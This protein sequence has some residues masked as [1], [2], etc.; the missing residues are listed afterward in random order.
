MRLNQRNLPPLL[1]FTIENHA[2]LTELRRECDHN[3]GNGLILGK[4]GSG[5]SY[6]AQQQ[7]RAILA[8]TNDM[9]FVLD[10]DGSYRDFTT[11][12]NGQLIDVGFGSDVRLNPLDIFFGDVPQLAYAQKVDFMTA[13]LETSFG[14]KNALTP[15]QKSL[16]DKA[17]RE[18]YTPYWQSL[19]KI[20]DGFD[21]LP[22][23][24]LQDLYD[25]L[26]G[27]EMAYKE[28][29]PLG[30][31]AALAELTPMLQ[32]FLQP[33]RDLFTGQ[34]N[35]AIEK[36]L[37]TY[38]FRN[39]YLPLIGT[40]MMAVL[41]KIRTAYLE[42]QYFDSKRK[43]WIFVDDFYYLVNTEASK[44][45]LTRFL[46]SRYYPENIFTGITQ[47]VSNLYEGDRPWWFLSNCH[48]L[49]LLPCT[50]LD[51]AQ[52]MDTLELSAEDMA[53]MTDPNCRHDALVILDFTKKAYISSKKCY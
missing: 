1:S 47:N 26:H 22:G 40:G 50:V 14:C 39:C 51:R 42:G 19:E 12:Q 2:H 36:R 33:D 27:W 37:V 48:Y 30:I 38:S 20:A 15:A 21:P 41:E 35:V 4:P 17:V 28:E 3:S 53:F 8:N 31:N 32:Y 46:L 11:E 18:A 7:I 43:V 25:I 13:W 45:W 6:T 49:H 24:T 16:I 5:K 10:S 9:V 23:P 44:E 29:D 34:S 52:L